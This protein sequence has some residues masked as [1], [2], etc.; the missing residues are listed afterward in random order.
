MILDRLNR[1][2]HKGW[3]ILGALAAIL[4]LA[5]PIG[6]SGYDNPCNADATNCVVLTQ[7]AF[8]PVDG[9][10]NINWDGPPRHNLTFA[11]AERY[12][13]LL[14]IDR[15]APTTFSRDFLIQED[16]WYGSSTLGRFTATFNSGSRT[17]VIS[18]SA[19]CCGA[20]ATPS[21]T[22]ANLSDGTFWMGCTKAGRIKANGPHGDDG[23]ATIRLEKVN[24]QDSVGVK[25]KFSSKHDVNCV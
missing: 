2:W 7:I 3:T 8:S 6:R 24:K 9:S 5:G 20:T 12:R 25:H 14:Q 17:P 1:H 19:R 23:H 16:R 22:P 21:G 18:Y 11:T 15:D 4:L 13:V 10:W